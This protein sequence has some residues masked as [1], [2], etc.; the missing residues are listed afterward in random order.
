MDRDSCCSPTVVQISPDEVSVYALSVQANH[1]GRAPCRVWAQGKAAPQVAS[2]ADAPSPAPA[3]PR[4]TTNGA[5]ASNGSEAAK[6]NGA[7]SAAQQ[8]GVQSAAAPAAEP[9]SNGAHPGGAEALDARADGVSEEEG[10]AAEEAAEERRRSGQQAGAS[11]SWMD[12]G[13]TVRLIRGPGG[14]VM[15]AGESG[16]APAEEVALRSSPRYVSRAFK[17][18]PLQLAPSCR[19]HGWPSRKQRPPCPS[20]AKQL[21]PASTR[22]ACCRTWTGVQSGVQL[23]RC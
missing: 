9:R 15:R 16:G 1:A 7:R 20:P 11:G 17:G 14:R 21:L 6:G 4:G 3:H 18:A 22:Y 8:A 12:A 5:A 10:A 13:R 19:P 23:T 2:P